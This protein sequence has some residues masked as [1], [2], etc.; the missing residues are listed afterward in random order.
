MSLKT[1]H[2][3]TTRNARLRIAKR[4]VKIVDDALRRLVLVRHIFVT[5]AERLPHSDSPGEAQ[6]REVEC[7]E[8]NTYFC[9]S[10]GTLSER[11]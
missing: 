9:S 1:T 6:T 11:P 5:S 4:F 10:H 3:R 7:I 2:Q 8:G